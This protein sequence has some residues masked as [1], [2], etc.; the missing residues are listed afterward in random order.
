M[1]GPGKTPIGY[2]QEVCSK[3]GITPTYDLVAT[4]GA[5]HEPTFV[6]RCTAGDYQATGKGP[7]KKKAKHEAAMAVLGTMFGTTNT[8]EKQGVAIPQIPQISDDGIPGN[9]IGQLQELTQKKKWAPPIYEFAQE[10]GPAHSR[11]FVCIVRLFNK[12]KETG[13]GKSKKSAKRKA[14]FSLLQRINQ[15]IN[16]TAEDMEPPE[17]F[18]DDT[19]PLMDAKGSYT[20]LKEG[21]RIPTITPHASKQI[22]QFYAKMKNSNG[23]YLIALHQKQLNTPASN[24]CQMLQEIAEEQRFEV[25]YVDL[26]EQTTDPSGKKGMRQCLVQLSTMPV[27]VCHGSGPHTDD[28]H[29]RAAQNALHYLKIMTKKA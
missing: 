4:E 9:P 14:A 16:L 17:E 20:A 21:R 11:E 5:V 22:G 3:R 23:K 15:G 2:L 6:F 7:N 12:I 24:Y 26:Q 29:A 8:A 13:L 10:Q 27:A 18:D 25:T 28:A 1:A 19:V